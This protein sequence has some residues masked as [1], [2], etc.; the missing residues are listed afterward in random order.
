DAPV[1]QDGKPIFQDVPTRTRIA[2]RTEQV[3]VVQYA[4]DGSRFAVSV[5]DEFGSL[6]RDTVLR[7]LHKCLHAEQPVDRRA[8]G[9]GVGLYLM[10]SSASTV[11]FH[12]APGVATEVVCVFDLEA[13]QPQL[14]HFGFFVEQLDTADGLAGPAR[15]FSAGAL[16]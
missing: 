2:L 6:D 13:P 16:R 12:V 4:F 7:V 8:S 11:Y 15:Q 1:D 5:R 14:R 3:V 10:A 9:A